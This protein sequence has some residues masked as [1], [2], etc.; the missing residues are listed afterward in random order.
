MTTIVSTRAQEVADD[1][2]G[3]CRSLHE[4]ASQAE[5]DDP[6]FMSELQL[7]AFECDCCGWWASTEE[8]NH[9]E[10]QEFDEMCDEC[11]DAETGEGA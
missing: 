5:A 10:G 4:F 2:I 3:T 6:N 11:A 8:L 1:L 7:L 9:D